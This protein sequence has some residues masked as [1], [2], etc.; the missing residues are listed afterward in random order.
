MPKP[1]LRVPHSPQEE[2]AGCLAACA[3]MVL[4]YYGITKSQATLNR[5]FGLTAI[6]TPYSTITRLAA[7]GAHVTLQCGDEKVLR[8]TLDKS[9]PL[10]VFLRTGELSYWHGDTS[11]AVVVIGYDD[12]KI[13]L[14][15]PAFA[16]AP[17]EATWGEFLLAWDHH[18][19]YFALIEV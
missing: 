2:P 4:A 19:D 17:A 15:D 1:L 18:D 8:S 12:E 7:L 5:L 10:I 16:S 13:Y 14:N 6:G 9:Q 11:H 3:Q